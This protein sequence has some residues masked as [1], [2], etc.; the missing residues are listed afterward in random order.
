MLSKTRELLLAHADKLPQ[1]DDRE[2]CIEIAD[3]EVSSTIALA[4]MFAHSAPDGALRAAKLV[5]EAGAANQI[6]TR[7]GYFIFEDGSQ[8]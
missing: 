1:G 8:L 6:D 3:L 5:A 2:K 4:L 7:T